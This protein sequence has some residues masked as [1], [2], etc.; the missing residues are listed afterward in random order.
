MS[1]A[2]S[3][4]SMNEHTCF[5][6]FKLNSTAN[7]NTAVGGVH[8]AFAYWLAAQQGMDSQGDVYVGGGTDTLDT[9]WH[10]AS[11]R[12][13]GPGSTS[14]LRLLFG[15]EQSRNAKFAS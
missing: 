9:N 13:S 15:L 11:A 4:P 12:Q 7:K 3:I 6:V 14:G 2:A 1:L 5:V 10:H 8:F